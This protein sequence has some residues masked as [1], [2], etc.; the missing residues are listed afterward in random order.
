MISSDMGIWPSNGTPSLSLS[1]LPPPTLKISN[2]SSKSPSGPFWT[3]LPLISKEASHGAIFPLI[4]KP[5]MFSITPKTGVFTFL[6]I[7]APLRTSANAM[8]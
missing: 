7:S 5:D 4:T 3:D 2:L 8:S 6:N 1:F